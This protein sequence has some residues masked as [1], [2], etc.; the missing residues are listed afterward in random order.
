[1]VNLFGVEYEFGTAGHLSI[2]EFPGKTASVEQ[3]QEM[4]FH[5]RALLIKQ[6]DENVANTVSILYGG[7]VK[8]DN[9]EALFNC[10]SVDGGLV[11]GA[12]LI[13]ADFE[14]IIEGLKR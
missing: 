12:S 6:Y 4:H 3:A 1:M 14:K 11:G 7:S 9:A 10:P 5:L 2:A 8:A 13:A